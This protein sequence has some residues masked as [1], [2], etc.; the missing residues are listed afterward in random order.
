MKYA[1]L[2]ALLLAACSG[3]NTKKGPEF[4]DVKSDSDSE[5]ESTSGGGAQGSHA[6]EQCLDNS[7][8]KVECMSD[9]DCCK[10]FY[11]GID[12]EGSTRIKTCIFGGK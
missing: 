8:G 4:P 2:L 10:G 11:C 12:P 7:G 3:S 6:P 1:T 9:T 5:P